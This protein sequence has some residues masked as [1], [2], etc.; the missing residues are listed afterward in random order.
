MRR[1]EENPALSSR[2][3][4]SHRLTAPAGLRLGLLAL[5]V[6]LLCIGQTFAQEMKTYIY[7]ESDIGNPANSNS[8]IALS[9]DGSGTL[10]PLPGSPFPTGGTGIFPPG[11]QEF[12]ADQQVMTDST[13]T[14][15]YAVNAHSNSIAGFVINPDGSLTTMPNSPYPSGGQDPVSIGLNGR[16]AVVVNKNEDRNQNIDG[17]LPNYT[18]FRV[19]R[20]GSFVINPDS[21][22]D[23][24]QHSSPSQ[25]LV[26]PRGHLVFG[27]EFQG[28]SKVTSYKYDRTGIM[29][30]VNFVLPTTM[31][32]D[33]QGL[34]L[35]PR[36]RILYAGLLRSKEVGVYTFDPTG[37]LTF[38]TSV[39]NTGDD[40]CWFKTNA[41]GTRLYTS[42]SQSATVS[43]YDLTNPLLPVFLQQVALTAPDGPELNI[44][45]DPTEKVLYSLCGRDV[46]VLSMDENGM[47]SETVPPYRFP[48]LASNVEPIGLAVVRK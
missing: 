41:A 6:S 31:R 28:D 16:F 8:I 7:V 48:G 12:N 22:I 34:V 13:G 26:S 2:I 20:D 36:K 4:T 14:Q 17:D 11:G 15:L 37:A 33:F 3:T 23:L 29:S 46:H 19:R 47:L 42:E 40:I 43:V 10:T 5:G 24:P 45:L 21:T 25:A 35:H 27:C 39:P 1:P 30:E 32:G 18:T 9:N 38:V 44:A